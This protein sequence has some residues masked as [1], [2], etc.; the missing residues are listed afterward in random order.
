MGTMSEKHLLEAIHS[1]IIARDLYTSLAQKS[2]VKDSKSILN[3][4]AKAEEKHRTTLAARYK[5]LFGKDYEYDPDL[6]AGPDITFLQHSVFEYTQAIE[7]L[8]IALSME[9]DAAA[10]YGKLLETATDP[11]DQKMLKSL[12]QFEE[13]HQDIIKVE[14]RKLE[15]AN[16]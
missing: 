14:M 4:L 15:A 1:E 8:R 9:I 16:K 5:S 6:N 10:F 13:S 2:V 12:I 11:E 7:A 3:E